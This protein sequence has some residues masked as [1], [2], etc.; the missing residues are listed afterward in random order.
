MVEVLKDDEVMYGLGELNTIKS[1]LFIPVDCI[2]L[3]PNYN[4]LTKIAG[5]VT[6]GDSTNHGLWLES[7]LIHWLLS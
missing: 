1:H 5:V 4:K 7:F 6:T 2:H 3:V